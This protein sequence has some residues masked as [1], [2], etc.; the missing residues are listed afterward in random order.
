M[1]ERIDSILFDMKESIDDF[2]NEV[3]ILIQELQIL[4]EKVQTFEKNE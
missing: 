3:K 1:S 4:K 2:G